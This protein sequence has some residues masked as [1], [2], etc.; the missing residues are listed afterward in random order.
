MDLLTYAPAVGYL[1]LVCCL[2]YVLIGR[3]PTWVHPAGL[4]SGTTARVLIE[5]SW[6]ATAI[7]VGA[8]AL[9]FVVLVYVAA[10]LVT[11]TSL[12][13]ISVTAALLPLVDWLGLFLG[14]GLAAVIAAWRTWHTL[15]NQRVS[16]LVMDTMDAMGVSGGRITTPGVDRIPTRDQ[17]TD[18]HESSTQARKVR[19]YV[20]PYLLAGVVVA[21]ALNVV[22]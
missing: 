18:V 10:N 19:M 15:G 21:A 13:A 20:P 5:G 16:W 11:G 17:L 2:L 9:V 6:H 14:L 7:S 4:V 1:T 22:L 8:A 12:F 3:C